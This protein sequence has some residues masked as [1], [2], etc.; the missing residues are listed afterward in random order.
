MQNCVFCLSH[1][2]CRHVDLIL[3]IISA[4]K[5]SLTMV[6]RFRPFFFV[7][8]PRVMFDNPFLKS[9]SPLWVRELV[10]FC[11]YITFM[12]RVS[13][14]VHTSSYAIANWA[15]SWQNQQSEC[16]PSED[17]DQPGHPPSLIRVFAVRIKKLGPLDTHWAH[18]EDS[19]QTGRMP[20]QIWVFAG[21]TATLLVLSRGGSIME[22]PGTL[23]IVYN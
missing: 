17:S 9:W 2:F 4:C 15:A 23:S 13:K 16:A 11:H 7:L 10:A 22:L 3:N 19:D 12:P 8:C 20:R 18:S 1:L 6:F 5:N 14:F 21:R